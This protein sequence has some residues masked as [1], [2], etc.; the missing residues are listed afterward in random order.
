MPL[1]NTEEEREL[2]ANKQLAVK[3]RLEQPVIRDFRRLF[4]QMGKDLEAFFSVTNRVP[5]AEEYADDV[6]AILRPHYRKVT[7]AFGGILM[8]F[9]E[10]APDDEPVI[11]ALTTIAVESDRD[12][13]AVLSDIQAQ[14]TMQTR[15]FIRE[16]VDA[17]TEKITVTNQ[18]QLN[19]AVS[20]AI[21]TLSEGNGAASTDKVAEEANS[22][23]VSL[24]SPRSETIAATTTQEAAE[25]VKS[26]EQNVLSE[27][28]VGA[29]F[30]QVSTKAW[31]TVGDD[32]VRDS[33][34]AANG[35]TQLINQPFV[36]MGQ[37][38]RFPGDS[39]L[40]A[41]A[42]NVINCRCSSLLIIGSDLT[43]TSFNLG[44]RG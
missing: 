18:T 32:R 13:E 43:R 38:L 23:F 8:E 15:A 33:H 28:L 6:K 12:I 22:E 21:A 4:K 37:L 17:E 42:A 35:Q 44:L 14:V 19:R 1:N 2:E 25:G 30:T 5:D 20:E 29:G 41:T 34:S 7:D 36:V 16:S 9:L 10:T 39:A 31:V 11:E 24:S 40:G 3:I 26:I 27:T